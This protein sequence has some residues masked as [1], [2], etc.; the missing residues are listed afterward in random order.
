M[1]SPGGRDLSNDTQS[2]NLLCPVCSVPFQK[3]EKSPDV[4]VNECL[5]KVST[6]ADLSTSKQSSKAKQLKQSFLKTKEN[7]DCKLAQK[8]HCFVCN[9][10]I[11]TYSSEARSLHIN[12][13]LDRSDVSASKSSSNPRSSAKTFKLPKSQSPDRYGP[14]ADQADINNF[15]NIKKEPNCHASGNI[16]DPD[17]SV[18]NKN[19]VAAS[20]KPLVDPITASPN[21]YVKPDSI[22]NVPKAPSLPHQAGYSKSKVIIGKTTHGS[23]TTKQRTLLTN[24]PSEQYSSGRLLLRSKSNSELTFCNNASRSLKATNSQFSCPEGDEKLVY[25]DSNDGFS[26]LEDDFQNRQSIFPSHRKKATTC[27][28][29]HSKKVLDVLD[30]FDDDLQTAKTLSVSLTRQHQYDSCLQNLPNTLLSVS[31][32]SKGSRGRKRQN[33]NSTILSENTVANKNP[34]TSETSNLL[35]PSDAINYLIQRSHCFAEQDKF[36]ESEYLEYRIIQN[37][38]AC[39]GTAIDNNDK[40]DINSDSASAQAKATKSSHSYWNLASCT[41]DSDDNIYKTHII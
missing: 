32:S 35:A 12:Q 30:E 27:R 36:R 28:N 7:P 16:F 39:G 4:H 40:I 41:V 9:K 31:S 25:A 2:E 29:Q 14:L 18:C 23:R 8:M 19:L 26:D 34:K 22:K 5:D 6:G 1:M 33:H 13:C 3:I 10:D 37:R 20:Q 24:K 15:T 11:T 17:K 21:N 38:P